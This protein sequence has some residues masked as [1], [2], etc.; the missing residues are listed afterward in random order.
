MEYLG[1]NKRLSNQPPP[2]TFSSLVSRKSSQPLL[3]SIEVNYNFKSRSKAN[4]PTSSN[5][6]FKRS[7]GLR[8]PINH[9]LTDTSTL[10]CEW[11]NDL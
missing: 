11:S 8:T 5:I 4:L 2:P 9:T 7:S 6:M 10:S 3:P 1:Q